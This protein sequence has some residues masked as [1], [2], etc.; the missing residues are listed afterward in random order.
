MHGVAHV[1]GSPEEREDKK[2]FIF[3][4][5]FLFTLP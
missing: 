5:V 2:R 4:L 3:A 1:Y